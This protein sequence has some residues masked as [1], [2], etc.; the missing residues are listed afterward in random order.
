MVQAHRSDLDCLDHGQQFASA[1][2]TLETI[3]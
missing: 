1:E 2:L 3:P